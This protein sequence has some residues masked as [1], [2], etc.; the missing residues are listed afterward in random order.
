M[1]SVIG[2]LRD[3]VK[4][5]VER[6]LLRG[7]MLRLFFVALI[8][9]A[10][11]LVCGL[12][13]AG[14]DNDFEHAGSA[15]WWA[16]LRLTDPGYLGDD[17]GLGRR[18]VSTFLTV[19]GY[20][21]FMGALVAI[22]TQWL[23]QAMRDL[24]AGYTPIVQADHVLVVGSTTRTATI[25]A[26]M[27]TMAG[28]VQ[29]FLALHETKR[30]NLVVL[31]DELT[32]DTR[33]DL[34]ERVGSVWREGRVVL[35]SG[36]PLRIEHLQRVDFLRASAILLPAEDLE[37][38]ESE[39]DTRTI[40]TL[41]SMSRYSDMRPA[42]LPLVVT[43]VFDARKIQVARRA[44]RGPVEVVASD[45][46]VARLLALCILHPG[47]SLVLSELLMYGEGNEVHVHDPGELRGMTVAAARQC[48]SSGI[49]LGLVKRASDGFRS[50]LSPHDDI[51]ISDEH[52]LIVLARSHEDAAPGEVVAWPD[53]TVAEPEGADEPAP[54]RI[55]VLGWSDR[56]PDLVA[57]LT[58]HKEPMT[59]TV[60]SSVPTAER[61]RIFEYNDLAGVAQNLLGDVT[62]PKV[63]E[64]ADLSQYDVVVFM[65]SD[66]LD[67][68]AQSD[69]RTILTYLLVRH[70]LEGGERT[71]RLIVELMDT[72][73]ERLVDARDVE[74][75]VSSLIIGRVLAHVALRPELR[76]VYDDLFSA[77]R[78]VLTIKPASAFVSA[79]RE[80]RFD[81]LCAIAHARGDIMLGIIDERG[82]QLNPRRDQRVFVTED[83]R[84]VLI[85]YD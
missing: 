26:E 59:I 42:E 40:K 57:E 45:Q 74:V 62:S 71:P 79:D 73:N 35:R 24:E 31:L 1:G 80:F 43:E 29:R 81:E 36:T 34:R 21:L 10:M 17:V 46:L 44:Y 67:S 25:V 68:G 33:Q 47:M 82:P 22:L 65:A 41:I 38:S 28:R 37:E 76:A 64:L 83:L 20:V 60:L 50:R 30:I 2:R 7:A 9:G 84:F 72:H 85:E 5:R 6:L 66:R 32:A 49:F 4:F 53:V 11:S 77:G 48:F 8:I 13:V 52:A 63:I 70:A 3:I 78:S 51:Q 61:E 56:V 19:A 12:I 55:L 15:I 75:L 16:F 54:H 58:A 14:L 69:A 23:N 18:I 27:L 39:S